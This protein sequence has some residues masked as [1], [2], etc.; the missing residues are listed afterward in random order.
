MSAAPTLT[1]IPKRPDKLQLLTLDQFVQRPNLSFLVRNVIPSQSIVVVFGPPKG[2]KTFSVC[3]LT[4]HAAHGQ[5]WQGFKV[6][7]PVRVAY[8]AGEGVNGLKVRLRA[9]LDQH[10]NIEEPGLFRILPESLAMPSR[11]QEV[12]EALREFNP[13]CVVVDTLNAYYGIGDENS[14]QDMTAFCNAVRLI[15][16]EI[17]CSVIVV[18]HTGH[19]DQTRERGSMVLRG[20]CDVLIQVAKGQEGNGDIGFQVAEARD[21]ETMP[22]ALALKLSRV[23]TE[24]KD[25][26]G[27]PLATCV[28]TASDGH[29]T[30]AGRGKPLRGVQEQVLATVRLMAKGKSPDTKGEVML[31][32]KDVQDALKEF[33]LHRQSVHK[34]FLSLAERGLFRLV[35]PGTILVKQQNGN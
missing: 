28:V 2:G 6:S 12:I 16:D 35:E 4:M 11:A 1:V 26:D 15:R 25:D 31:V 21:M 17:G 33:D 19:G 10:D 29:V 23:E 24:W 3:D 30:L 18:H 5:D 20:T 32:K 7:K 27:Q 8:L 34:A 14:T 9:W 13:D 22:Q